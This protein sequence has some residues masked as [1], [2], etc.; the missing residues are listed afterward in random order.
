[1]TSPFYAV[2]IY[3]HSPYVL[4][5]KETIGLSIMYRTTI[6]RSARLFSTSTTV[7]KTTTEKVK[8]TGDM[9]SEIV[10]VALS[11][12]FMIV[13]QVNKKVGKTLAAGIEK[14]E[15]VTESAKDTLG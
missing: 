12:L 2:G 13:F 15:Q 4:V 10:F 8:E 3:A 9:V 1:M 14:G 5:V 7:R 11:A 6:I